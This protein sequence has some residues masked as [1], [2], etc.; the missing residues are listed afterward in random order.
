MEP[1]VRLAGGTRW[2]PAADSLR[3]RGSTGE[4]TWLESVE[5]TTSDLAS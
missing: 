5:D 4:P 2:P 1:I 3:L